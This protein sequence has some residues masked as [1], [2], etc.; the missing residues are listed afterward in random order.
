MTVSSRVGPSACLMA[1]DWRRWRS[2]R[3]L[4]RAGRAGRRGRREN[5]RR[6]HGGAAGLVDRDGG[7]TKGGGLNRQAALVLEFQQQGR[8]R[9]RRLR[10][11]QQI[12]LNLGASFGPH[13]PQLIEGFDALRG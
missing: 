9:A 8:D 4:C 11:A 12:A 10:P 7:A 2:A 5:Y 6:R 1:A 13:G 3:S